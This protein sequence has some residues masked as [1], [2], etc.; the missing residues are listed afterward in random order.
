MQNCLLNMYTNRTY[1]TIRNRLTNF[2]I[3]CMHFILR[4]IVVYMEP[5]QE[6]KCKNSGWENT[7]K[8][9]SMCTG[10]HYWSSPMKAPKD[11]MKSSLRLAA[12]DCISTLRCVRNDRQYKRRRTVGQ[13]HRGHGILTWK[14]LSRKKGKNHGHQPANLHYIGWGNKRRGFTTFFYPKTTA[15]MRYI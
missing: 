9:S 6:M 4:W 3:W 5:V 10:V 13:T 2:N 14:A 11:N 7:K 15:Y 1:K 8:L 12:E